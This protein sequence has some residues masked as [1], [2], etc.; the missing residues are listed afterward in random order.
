MEKD[1]IKHIAELARL[2]LA[3]AEYEQ[4]AREIEAV[5]AYVGEVQSI[6]GDSEAPSAG[7]VR[8][9]FREDGEP[10]AA[11]AYS[12]ALLDEVPRVH[13]GYIQVKQILDKKKGI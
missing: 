2:E 6:A 7:V 12:E 3:D 11:G 5:L 9:V 1:E 4:Y 13:E 10:H 8:N